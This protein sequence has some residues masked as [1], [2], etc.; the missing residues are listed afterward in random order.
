[1]E[2]HGTVARNEEAFFLD[3]EHF[4]ITFNLDYMLVV[5]D[6]R[7]LPADSQAT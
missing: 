2:S 7:S 4:M 5:L 3:L 6:P 1:M